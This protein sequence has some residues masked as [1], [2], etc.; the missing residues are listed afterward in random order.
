[1]SWG[2]IVAAGI[3]VG[4]AAVMNNQNQG[5]NTDPYIQNVETLTPDQK[6][7]L[8]QLGWMVGGTETTPK[9]YRDSGGEVRDFDKELADAKA[10]YDKEYTA[11]NTYGGGY[12]DASKAALQKYNAAKAEIEKTKAS[13]AV[14]EKGATGKEGLLTAPG[15]VPPFPLTAP[16]TPLTQQT[17]NLAGAINPAAAQNLGAGYQNLG[18]P[19]EQIQ[20]AQTSYGTGMQGLQLPQAQ[21]NAAMTSYG[22]GMQ[23]LASMAGSPYSA[24]PGS[25]A[26]SA[27]LLPFD[28]SALDQYSRQATDY[29]SQLSKLQGQAGKYGTQITGYE[30]N[31]ATQ[32]AAA[33]AKAEA[34]AQAKAESEAAKQTQISAIQAKI[35]A[36]NEKGQGRSGFNSSS[37]TNV[38]NR[39]IKDYEEQIAQIQKGDTQSGA[40][41][42][43]GRKDNEAKDIQRAEEEAALTQQ[44]AAKQYEQWV[45]GK[46]QAESEM[47]RIQGLLGTTQS[48]LEAE[49]TQQNTWEEQNQQ[50]YISQVQAQE[51]A[52]AQ[53]V[54][55]YAKSQGGQAFSMQDYMNQI[56]NPMMASA[57][58]NF[59]NRTLPTI[60]NA[61]GAQ[62]SARS[63]GMYDVLGR[64]AGDM[65]QNLYGELSQG[66]FNAE[67]AAR[68][69]QLQAAQYQTQ[70]GLQGM[71][72]GQQ[73]AQSQV[74]A[75]MS[76]AQFGSD[77]AGQQQQLAQQNVA[78]ELQA[79]QMGQPGANP[80]LQ[81]LLP[82]LFTPASGAIGMPGTQTP[83][84]ASQIL[85]AMAQMYGQTGGFNNMFGNT[86]TNNT[87]WN[88]QK[89]A[90]NDPYYYG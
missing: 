49:R 29:Q 53:A 57:F 32:Q 79:W 24:P 89:A 18:I 84:T 59:Q 30:Q 77:I 34:D 15:N 74:Q 28:T 13:Y 80:L 47:E 73:G 46:T 4:G 40:S 58:G 19:Q 87:T 85:P 56:G 72:L 86:E 16:A 36:L 50:S 70:A 52:Q 82:Y 9:E 54:E 67:Q 76:G 20:A 2:L 42:G 10:V 11:A 35:D 55:S 5:G 83:S 39:Q 37:A 8:Q 75:G 21:T 78:G 64:S 43:W 88:Q 51:Q 12:G 71:G 38:K 17:Q 66:A 63:S 27:N 26:F 62:D 14:W 61:F 31:L 7:L 44:R 25:D 6:N 22:Q 68:N 81:Q 1:M 90:M 3:S 45:S 60:A 33:Q 41:K 65:Y 69:R 23:G 48:G